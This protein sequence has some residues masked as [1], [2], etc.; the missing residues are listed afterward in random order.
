MR[1]GARWVAVAFCLLY[2]FDKLTGA[3]FTILDSELTKPMG[4]VSG[5]WLTWY[6]FGYSP[7]YGTLIALTQIGG[8]L[9]VAFRHTAL[10][11]ALIL[12][13]VFVNIILIDVCFGV[14]PGATIVALIVLGCLI[15]VIAPNVNA[16]KAAV[17]QP[18]TPYRATPR[19]IAVGVLLVSAW[20]FSHW[21]ANYNNRLPTKIDGIWAVAAD[22]AAR[23]PWR[24]LFF[25][26]NRAYMGDTTP[27][28][29][30]ERDY[31]GATSGRHP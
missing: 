30:F 3:Q 14:D 23:S 27:P 15:A 5:F 9:L 7:V 11:G 25:E 20:A 8:G 4:Q 12:V 26:Y 2:G 31:T 1:T 13:P 18:T 6:Y 10:V 21:T 28:L 22:S 19:V 16:L 29:V 17:L 24:R